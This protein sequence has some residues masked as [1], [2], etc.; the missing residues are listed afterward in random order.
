MFAVFI[1]EPVLYGE[2]LEPIDEEY[3]VLKSYQLADFIRSCQDAG[4]H[5][6]KTKVLNNILQ[7]QCEKFKDSNYC[8]EFLGCIIFFELKVIYE[9]RL[10]IMSLQEF[11]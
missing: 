7:K 2:K 9:K 3:L 8:V 10:R 4:Q 5:F 11:H 1:E 6:P